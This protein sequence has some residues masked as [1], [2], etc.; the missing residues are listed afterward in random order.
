MNEASAKMDPQSPASAPQS[1]RAL[2]FVLGVL[3]ALG[4]A[5]TDMYLPSLPSI[6]ES[7]HASAASVQFTLA[8]FMIGMGIGQLAYGPMSDRYGRRIPLMF[9]IS[10]F[11]VASVACT[12][13]PTIEA[14][15]ATRFLQALGAAAG[16]VVAR[17][18][19]RDLYTG[20]EIARVLSLMMLVMGAVP[21]LAPLA[22]G[23]LLLFF[24]W[25]AIFGALA[26]FGLLALTLA[27]FAVPRTRATEHSGTLPQN[28]AALIADPLF[29]GG[30]VVGAFGASALFAYIASASFV[31]MTVFHFT[32]QEFAVTFGMNGAGFIGAAQLNR[33][34]LARFSMAALR[35]CAALIMCVATSLLVLEVWW[36]HAGVETVAF[37]LFGC[38]A[39]IGM[40]LPNATA[41]A[42]GNHAARAGVASSVIGATHFALAA[43]VTVLLSA[44]QDG[45]ARW[46][47]I[48]LV[49]C[50]FGALATSERLRRYASS[51]RAAATTYLETGP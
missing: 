33:F 23:G 16:P 35:H 40:L 31:F 47:A 11:V 28:F 24:G 13:A 9:G 14:L 1:R 7:L 25:R 26:L 30:T 15:I 18:V 27:A 42:L 45:S 10:L 50:G 8:T 21:I 36:T 20:R 49:V 5:S 38:I 32:P 29:V 39:S 37:T 43:L 3:T 51:S 6:G 17:A 2:I 22:G 4:A 48:V 19:V 41:T 34:L 44:L 12:Y 46:M